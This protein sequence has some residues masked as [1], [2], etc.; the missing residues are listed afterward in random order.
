MPSFG[1]LT[2]EAF[3][4]AALR[5]LSWEALSEPNQL[6]LKRGVSVEPEVAAIR[7][8]PPVPDVDHAPLGESVE[9]YDKI[10]AP[11]VCAVDETTAVGHLAAAGSNACKAGSEAKRRQ[12]RINMFL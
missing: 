8:E 12:N 11:A 4:P 5:Q 6:V 9:V 10:D 7:R 2:F 1:K 3:D